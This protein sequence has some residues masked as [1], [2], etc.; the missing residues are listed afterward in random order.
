MRLLVLLAALTAITLARPLPGQSAEGTVDR[1]AAVDR[2]LARWT[3]PDRPG[4]VVVVTSG[5]RVVMVRGYGMADLANGIPNGPETVFDIASVSKQFT[6][7]LVAGLIEARR[8]DPEAEVRSLLPWVPDFGVPLRVRHLIHHTS[9]LRDW[10]GALALAGLRMDDAITFDRIRNLVENQRDLN[11]E[12]GS[13]YLYSNTGYN[14]LAAIVERL[15][16]ASFDE[17]S[18]REIFVPL[19]MTRSYVQDDPRRDAPGRAKSYARAGADW[20]P[21]PNGLCGLGSSS[22][23]TTGADL[24]RWMTNFADARVGGRKRLLA[25][26][27]RE[28]L[29]GGGG[30]AYAYGQLVVRREGRLRIDHSGSWAGFRSGLVR[31]PAEK[32]AVAVLGNAADLPAMKLCKEIAALYLPPAGRGKRPA[33]GTAGEKK[34]ALARPSDDGGP[35]G[36]YLSAELGAVAGLRPVEGGILWRRADGEEARLRRID[37][38]RYEGGPW[39]LETIRVV[40][41]AEGTPREL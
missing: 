38:D 28:P 10:P 29:A 39:W 5:D 27:G 35:E 30:N 4:A 41:D 9:G 20:A 1:G 15:G 16:G 26:R 23:H 25:M 17:I 14:L 31:F 33:P 11:F 37:D 7:F 6:G 34:V 22:L 3:G 36:R 32:I 12:P 19:G 18:R 2:L 24:A 21:V 40:R 8:L 13:E